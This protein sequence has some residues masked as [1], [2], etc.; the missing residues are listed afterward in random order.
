MA[1]RGR[2][3][4]P[5][6]STILM[7]KQGTRVS[8]KE[9]RA[10]INRLVELGAN[11]PAIAKAAGL[12]HSTVCNV[13]RYRDKCA[14]S[15]SALILGTTIT[16]TLPH[17]TVVDLG[18]LEVRLR[19]AQARGWSQHVIAR[20]VG[21]AQT[22]IYRCMNSSTKRLDVGIAR[23]IDRFLRKI[24]GLQGPSGRARAEAVRKSWDQYLSA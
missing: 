16:D 2:P 12:A 21:V 15:T 20:E 10:H 13:A 9:A 11:L 17:I 5:N 14:Q 22:M 6:G 23:K 3:V 24:D 18:G 4:G 19:E 7:G 8:T 1:R